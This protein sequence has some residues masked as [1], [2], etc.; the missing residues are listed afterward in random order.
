MGS[1]QCSK[2]VESKSSGYIQRLRV[3]LLNHADQPLIS[4]LL[5]WY[6]ERSPEK[7][8][9]KR[10]FGGDMEHAALVLV[11][12]VPHRCNYLIVLVFLSDSAEIFYPD[13]ARAPRN[14]S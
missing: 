9:A 14:P 1:W 2:R 7:S 8:S 4:P 6:L 11:V 5:E 10:P 13:Q 12:V 3:T